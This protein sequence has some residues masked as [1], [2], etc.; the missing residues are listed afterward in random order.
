MGLGWVV[1]LSVLIGLGGGLWLDRRLE[2]T[3]LF[4]LIG[5]ALGLAAAARST[6]RMIKDIRPTPRTGQPRKRARWDRR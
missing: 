1:V 6:Y 4:L 2:T 3:P 5:L